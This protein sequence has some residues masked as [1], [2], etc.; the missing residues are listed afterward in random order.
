[1]H[2][3]KFRTAVFIIITASILLRLGFLIFG[4]VLPV[5]WDAR[6]YAAAGLA[7][8]SYVDDSGVQ[9][10]PRDEREDRYQFKHYY[11]KYLDGEEIEWLMYTP[12]SLS[13]AREE[14]YFSGPLYPMILA[15]VMFVSPI[16]DFTIIRI[17]GIGFDVLANLLLIFI[18]LRLIGRRAAILA[19]ALY[20]A[21][22]PFIMT[23][24]M[25][26]LETPTSLLILLT[27]Y[28]L[29]RGSESNRI[30]PLIFAGLCTG[31]LVLNKPTAML[32]VVPF[33]IGWAAY[34][35]GNWRTSLFV[36]RS[37]FYLTPVAV[38]FIGWTAIAS[39]HYG[40]L[41]LRDPEYAGANIRQSSS[42]LYEGY[43]LD[44]VEP[45]FWD[46]PYLQNIAD[47]PVGYAGLMV[48]KFDR[49]WTRPYNDF[50]K[51]FILPAEGNEFIHLV[52]VVA[53]LLGLLLL[54]RH[55]LKSAT[56]P[57]LIIGYYTGIHLI[58]HSISR[59]N[60]QAMTMVMLGA[61][62]G[63]ILLSES[64]QQRER[65]T[66][67]FAAL[68]LLLAAW[69]ID[70][71]WFNAITGAG[72][73]RFVV[74]LIV[75]LKAALFL[76]GLILLVKPLFRFGKARLVIPLATALIITIV[77]AS[78]T[79]SRNDW[80]EFKCPLSNPQT[81]AGIRLYISNLHPV[82]ENDLLAL[83]VDINAAENTPSKPKFILGLGERTQN[84]T[85]GEPPV[86]QGFYPKPTY[87]FYSQFIPMPT[88]RF[89]QYAAVPLDATAIENQ[90]DRIGFLDVWI[91]TDNDYAINLWGKVPA[92]SDDKHYIPGWRFSSIER[93]VHEDDPRIRYPVKY[94]SDSTV[95][96][97][98]PRTRNNPAAGEDLSPLAGKQTGRYN[99]FLM[100]FKPD[101]S[102]RVY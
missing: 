45:G 30:R 50:R 87:R 38:V 95:S 74:I 72:L 93:F 33:M 15:I 86:S 78:N 25:L 90:L 6:R 66:G 81:K 32:L 55:N 88:T 101:G 29:L 56:W 13:L 40:E 1:M 61:A 53:G 23:S 20:A 39:S 79:L 97:Y 71:G 37:L 77:G 41:T 54:L 43:D 18:A 76:Y 8:I 44:K 84:F 70:P 47:D 62:Y 102:V 89:R 26:L 35:W 83:M 60:F 57:L 58:F 4:D 10:L 46:R 51:D 7:L 27:L 3:S 42:M 75:L 9:E 21:Y 52:V 65:L 99:I 85:L 36:N 91:S 69:L 28:L 22:F 67:I 68:A 31:G 80:A 63:I 17:I 98:I 48:K 19:G 2:D 59:Y 49:L 100:H 16:A 73:S 82:A 12:H 94:L 11:D 14:I 24:T 34:T 96:Y 92:D 64:W 5:M